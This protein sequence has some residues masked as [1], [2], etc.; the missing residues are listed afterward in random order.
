[1]EALTSLI[2]TAQSRH[3][4]VGNKMAEPETLRVPMDVGAEASGEA[5]R[6]EANCELRKGRLFSGNSLDPSTAVDGRQ[7]SWG[8]TCGACRPLPR[9]S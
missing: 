8:R 5:P 7:E 4:R 2:K 9:E 1:L 6:R 3:H